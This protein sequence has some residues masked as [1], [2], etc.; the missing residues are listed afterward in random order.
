MKLT[1]KIEIRKRSVVNKLEK[2]CKLLQS[3]KNIV[4][5]CAR[6]YFDKTG[7][8]HPFL[9]KS[10]LDRFIKKK[11]SLNVIDEELY[12]LQ[13]KLYN[14]W[15]NEIGSDTTKSLVN[16]LVREFK[17]IVGKWKAGKKSKLPVPRKIST[18][19]SFT[20]E[21]NPNMIVD[22]RFSK[23]GKS[24][25]VVIRL[26][27]KYGAIRFKIPATLPDKIHYKVIWFKDD[28]VNIL[29]TYEVDCNCSLNLDPSNYI[30]IDIGIRNFI[31]AISNT[32]IKSFIVNGNPLKS[33]NQW[34]NKLSAKLSSCNEKGLLQKLWRY[35]NKRVLH[36]VHNVA[37]M[38][39][40]ICLENRIG[41]IIVPESLLDEYQKES[42]MSRKFNQEFRQIPFGKF[43]KILEYKCK[44]YNIRLL[45]VN[46]SYTSK[47]SSITDRIENKE[48]SKKINGVRIKRGL[49][50]DLKLNK[51]F[52]A[53]LNGALN[54]AIKALG[55]FAR[56]SLM[57]NYKWITKLCNPVKINLFKTYSPS[58]VLN[59]I[60]DSSSYPCRG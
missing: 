21:T 11:V 38:L 25:H 19:Y 26:C 18:L 8:I 22:K 1:L 45:K 14:M 7:E 29:A 60:G 30:S 43:I 55:K 42:K 37:N 32:N 3:F 16:V 15:K 4:Y 31:S 10:W 39:V 34:V 48:A 58:Q 13:D 17:S 57:K 56:Q 46:E 50:K 40:M 6:K 24:N 2:T 41:T 53:D 35:R 33:F 49:F 47:L 12:E 27:K 9:N 36:F 5:I 59:L 23:R 28:V 51:V 44:L 52:N 20:I 54:I